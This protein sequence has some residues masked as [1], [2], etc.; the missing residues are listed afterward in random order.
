MATEKDTC[1]TCRFWTR[2]GPICKI[3]DHH[4]TDRGPKLKFRHAKGSGNITL[5]NPCMGKEGEGY[6][7]LEERQSH[8]GS[9]RCPKLARTERAYDTPIDGLGYIDGE[10]YQVFM[11]TAQGFGCVHHEQ[12]R[13]L[14]PDWK[15]SEKL[16]EIKAR[17]A[18]KK[19]TAF[20]PPSAGEQIWLESQ[21][22]IEK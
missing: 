17:R 22:D 5:D 16:Q 9:C 18:Q 12:M 8:V 15:G 19:C 13:Y 11:W 10:H 20:R 3:I 7:V 1:S 14:D 6:E 4:S 21:E 2:F